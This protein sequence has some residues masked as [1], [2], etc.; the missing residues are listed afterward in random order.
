[1]KSHSI[2]S[3]YRLFYTL[4]SSLATVS[5]RGIGIFT[6]II[7]SAIIYQPEHEA[8]IRARLRIIQETLSDRLV[9]VDLK[10]MPDFE[11]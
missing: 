6:R 2:L 1:M 7:V 11:D 3:I 10:H 8:A 9:I 4:F 5:R